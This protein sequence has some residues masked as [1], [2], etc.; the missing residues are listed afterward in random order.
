MDQNSPRLGYAKKI[1][2]EAATDAL[3]EFSRWKHLAI[4]EKGAQDFVSEVDKGTELFLR[5]K[6][7]AE[8]PDDGIV[9]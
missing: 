4:T 7:E 2:K 3:R 9:G 5:S 1:V 8:F 6:I